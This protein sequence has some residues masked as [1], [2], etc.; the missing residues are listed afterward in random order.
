[1]RSVGRS[2]GV[3]FDL[4]YQRSVEVGRKLPPRGAQC[5]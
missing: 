5:H 2:S 4:R 1:M 3:L